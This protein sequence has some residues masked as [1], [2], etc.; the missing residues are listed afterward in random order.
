MA[1][2]IPFKKWV[3]ESPKKRPQLIFPHEMIVSMIERHPL[4]DL[5]ITLNPTYSFVKF[6]LMTDGSWV[7]R[8]FTKD[9]IDGGI[10]KL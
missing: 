5:M 6:A 9:E 1:D 10:D 4:V 8:M 2:I 3:E 7:V